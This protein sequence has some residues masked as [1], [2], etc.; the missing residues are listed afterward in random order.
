MF[1]EFSRKDREGLTIRELK[2]TYKSNSHCI[3]D[4]IPTFNLNNLNE[5]SISKK[6][7]TF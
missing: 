1:N 5:T 4:R 3:T 2:K 7:P 6:I